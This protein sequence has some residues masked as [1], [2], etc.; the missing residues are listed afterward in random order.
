MTSVA[1]KAE[2]QAFE[3]EC[4]VFSKKHFVF[5]LF[6][7]WIQKRNTI[8]CYVQLT[9]AHVQA[10]LRRTDFFVEP[11]HKTPGQGAAH[12]ST[13]VG[14]GDQM[15]EDKG[16]YRAWGGLPQERLCT[17]LPWNLLWIP[18]TPPYHFLPCFVFRFIHF[19]TDWIFPRLGHLHHIISVKR[20]PYLTRNNCIL[21]WIFSEKILIFSFC[22]KSLYSGDLNFIYIQLFNSCVA[23]DSIVRPFH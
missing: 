14:V 8:T 12:C 11:S 5:V 4:L 16:Q 2:T 23:V 17:Q 21:L 20:H 13:Q 1:G 3:M 9:C 10:V 6:C 15:H 22:N 18:P 19:S 7:F